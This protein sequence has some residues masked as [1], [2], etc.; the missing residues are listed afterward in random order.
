MEFSRQERWSGLPFPP[1]GDAP[2]QGIE[3]LSPVAA[4]LGGRFF[5]TEPPAKSLQIVLYIDSKILTIYLGY[6]F[7]SRYIGLPQFSSVA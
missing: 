4:E 1:P 3:P 5:T 6:H 7:I 2:N